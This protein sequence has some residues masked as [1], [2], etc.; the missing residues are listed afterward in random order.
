[1]PFN[2]QQYNNLFV[3]NAQEG[4]A[5]INDAA[6]YDV[7]IVE[8]EVADGQEYWRVIGV[9]HLYPRE[10]FGNHH[11]YLEALDEN[12][13]R[14]N[15]PFAWAGWT[16]DGR[17]P[18]QRADPI[19]L[20][21]PSYEAAGNI[22][23]HI[24]QTV[25]V[26][27]KG[28]SPDGTDLSDKVENIHT[29]HPD[30]PLEDGS[31]LNSIGH[32]SFYV[33][34]Q[35]TIKTG[36]PAQ[37]G[38]ITGQ[39]TRGAGYTVQLLKH[40][41]VIAEQVLG[42]SETFAFESLA[43]GTYKIMVVNTNVSQDNIRLDANNKHVNVTLALPPQT[44]SS[45]YGIVENGAG[46][47]LLLIKEGNI[48]AR[49]TIPPS[50]AYRFVNLAAGVYSLQL[51]DTTARQDNISVDGTNSRE[52]NLIVTDPGQ[53]EKIIP[54]YILFGPPGTRGR[55]VNWQLAG[56][57]MVAFSLTA[58]FS[59]PEA[60]L[61]Q[62]VT[63]IGEGIGQTQ[64]DEIRA[65]GSQLEQLAGDAYAIEEELRRRIN[66]GTAFPPA[67]TGHTLTQ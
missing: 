65:S 19:L 26:W 49:Q 20:D 66:N 6:A 4:G 52:V 48:L 12:G 23:M 62:R 27:I 53:P 8:T 61:A 36:S 9:H 3:L 22:A 29:R 60:K 59:V 5:P 24:E 40:M 33:V 64:Q 10:N 57:Y 37:D 16:W 15:S 41:Q 39:V 58:G 44:K 51:F 32:H 67:V 31:L 56:D 17:Q 18:G 43:Y 42:Q 13:A 30:E 21:K 7:R 55:T 14:I 35:R 46:L 2:H 38:M 45:I 63:I 34:F 50:T 11:V 1:V 25:A 28:L 54:H 47:T